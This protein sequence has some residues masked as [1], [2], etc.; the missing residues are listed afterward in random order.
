M[1]FISANLIT[2][3]TAIAVDS[4]TLTK[5]NILF[6]DKTQQY[7][8]VG[9]DDDLTTTS[10]TIS[11]DETTTLDRLAL[12]EMNWKQFNI[13]YN[14]ATANALSLTTTA[15]T[16][17]SQWTSNSA[18]SKYLRFDSV[19]VTSLT[20]DV[21]STIVADSEKAIGYLAAAAL[22]LDFPRIPSSKDYKP[23][24]KPEETVHK[25]SDGGVRLQKISEKF[26]TSIKF[27]NITESFRNNLRTVYETGDDFI[28]VAFGTATGWDEV[29]YPVVWS[30]PFD[31]YQYSD[32]AVA[33]GFSGKISLME[34]S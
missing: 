16:T 7:F 15:D 3:S 22:S 26:M 9:F 13:Y 24:F 17:T 2:T 31:F 23:V 5:E 29:C 25:L 27:K 6:R 1:E 10:I 34:T 21:Y 11:F 19:D 33:A 28:F 18:T 8:S 4:N 12:I 30:G 20:F 14:G 32:D